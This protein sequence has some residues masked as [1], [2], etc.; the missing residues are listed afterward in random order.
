VVRKFNLK[1]VAELIGVSSNTITRAVQRNELPPGERVRGNRLLF[2]L[3]E[4]REIQK[5]LDLKPWRDPTTDK[6]VIVAIANFKGGVGKTSTAIHLGQYFALR[7]YRVLMIDLDA[8]ASLTTLLGLLPDSEVATEKTALPCLEGETPAG[9]C[10]PAHLLA[11]S[12][13]DRRQ[14]RAL[15]GGVFAREPPEVGAQFSLL[16]GVQGWH[17]DRER[18]LSRNEFS[19]A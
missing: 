18:P 14:S 1:E 10:G 15:W 9:G 12:G 16:P 11:R 7:V 4:I 5:R 19:Y 17:R 2:T 8:Q 3:E 6:A 13:S